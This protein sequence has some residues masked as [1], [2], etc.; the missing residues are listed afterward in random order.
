MGG[1]G[2]AMV[3]AR[4]FVGYHFY[5]GSRIHSPKVEL[6]D[7]VDVRNWFYLEDLAVNLL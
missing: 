6:H 7:H 4:P 1:V 3:S 5:S 2:I